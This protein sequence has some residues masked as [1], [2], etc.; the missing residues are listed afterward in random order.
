MLAKKP[1]SSLL[2]GPTRAALCVVLCAAGLIILLGGIVLMAFVTFTPGFNDPD[3]S[4]RGVADMLYA[5]NEANVWAWYASVLLA[6]LAAAFVLHAF[7][8]R[9]AGRQVAPYLVLAGLAAFMSVDE[10]AILHEKLSNIVTSFPTWGWLAIGIPLVV[11][12]GAGALWLTRT[13]EQFF[14]RRLIVAGALFLLGAV[15]T[16]GIAGVTVVQAGSYDAGTQTAVYMVLLA[17]EEFLELAGVLFALWATL[18]ALDMERRPE[19]LRVSP[20]G[21]QLP[22]VRRAPRGR[23]TPL[24]R[25]EDI[26]GGPVVADSGEPARRSG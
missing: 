26:T 3:S 21:L 22:E 13:M 18:T 11:V 20:A 14:R 8:E 7:V 2:D 15:F 24:A 16:E 17:I 9:N 23:P 10:A 6:T 25:V 4:L 12:V 5:D 1:L 19:G